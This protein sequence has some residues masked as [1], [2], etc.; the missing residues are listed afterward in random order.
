MTQPNTSSP[1]DASPDERRSRR[2]A[3]PGVLV[4][5]DAPQLA[6]KP[7]AV[8]ALD[9]N[10]GG[11]GLVLPEELPNG[12]RVELSFRLS[13]DIEFARLPAEVRHKW[14]SSGGVAFLEWPDHER[15]RLLEYLVQRFE[16]E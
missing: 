7:W 2:L 1:K 10:A 13:E 3:L 6:P 8:D 9:I 11:L 12:M 4:A 14:G 5:I 16:D 15:L